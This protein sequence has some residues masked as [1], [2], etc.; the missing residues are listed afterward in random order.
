MPLPALC[1]TR[2]R[3]K[4]TTHPNE[5]AFSNGRPSRNSQSCPTLKIPI[6]AICIAISS[7]P[8]PFTSTSRNTRSRKPLPRNKLA[9]EERTRLPQLLDQLRAAPV[10]LCLGGEAV[11]RSGPRTSEY[12]I[13]VFRLRRAPL[14]L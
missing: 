14:L 8:I 12:D 7:S 10:F 11:A 3:R 1:C 13:G 6:V 9:L 5:T 4:T 2:C